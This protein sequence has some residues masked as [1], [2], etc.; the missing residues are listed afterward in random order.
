MPI[1]TVTRRAHF[2]S[3]HRLHRDDWSE[4]KNLRVFGDCA[5]PNW[6]GH[7]YEL[8]VSVRGP[9]DPET[10]FVMNLRILKDVIQTRVVADVDH[11]NLNLE[12]PWLSGV[13]PSTENL[14]VAIWDR[15]ADQLPE[16]ASLVSVVIKETRNN[17]VEYLGPEEPLPDE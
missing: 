10:G 3:A 1:V 4:E 9:V 2:S 7:N 5:N 11:K 14:A 17:S 8:V 16:P 13:N 12:V 6:H 15:I